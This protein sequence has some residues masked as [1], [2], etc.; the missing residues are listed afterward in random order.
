M[1]EVIVEAYGAFA[2][3]VPLKKTDIMCMPP[4]RTPRTIVQ[5]QAAKEIY[6]ETQSFT[7]LGGVV[8]GISHMSVEIARRT[9]AC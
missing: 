8:T 2:L 9:R 7:Y 3:T 5:V 4:P 1:T 6:K